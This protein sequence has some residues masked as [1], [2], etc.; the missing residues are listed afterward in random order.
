[1]NRYAGGSVKHFERSN[2]L[3]TALYKNIR[4]L[5]SNGI[6]LCTVAHYLQGDR[7]GGG[8]E[9]R[10]EGGSNKDM[11]VCDVCGA[12]LIVGDAQQR[13]DEHIMGKQHMGYARIRTFLQ[14]RDEVTGASLA[15]AYL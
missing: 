11:E 12:L 4:F 5:P 13:I 15:S 1:M 9:H 14:N 3:D 10:G 2:G 6:F 8:S 7:G